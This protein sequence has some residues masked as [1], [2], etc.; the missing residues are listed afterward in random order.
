M[1]WCPER[2]H[3][4]TDCNFYYFDEKLCLIVDLRYKNKTDKAME[5]VQ[6]TETSSQNKSARKMHLYGEHKW[7][8]GNREA[9]INE[10]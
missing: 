9:Q 4:G 2:W 7:G 8:T 10:K 6:H 5:N 3:Q 1:V